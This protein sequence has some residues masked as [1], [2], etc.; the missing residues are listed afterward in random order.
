MKESFRSQFDTPC[1]VIDEEI[2]RANIR[3][4]QMEAQRYGCELRP[5][6]KTHKTAY[7]AKLQLEAGAC[8]ITSCKVSEAERMAGA[9]MDD[10][11]I[12]Y[13][14]VGAKKLARACALSK[15]IKRL[16][17]AVDNLEQARPL[18]AAAEANHCELEVRIEVDC[19]GGRTGSEWEEFA[20][21]VRFVEGAPGLRLTGLYTFRGL[22]GGIQEPAGAAAREVELMMAYA[23]AAE[24]ICGRKLE[25]S[26]GST[27]T[28]RE[29]A[30]TGKVTEIRPGTYVFSDYM[31]HKECAAPLERIAARL[32]VTVVSVHKDYVVV[33]GGCKTFPTDPLL[34]QPPYFFNSYAYFPDH[35][36]LR[37]RKLTE[38]HGMVTAEGGPLNLKVGDILEAIPVHICPA[39]NLQNQIYIVNGEQIREE[40][41]IGR[42]MLQ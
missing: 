36:H 14:L 18:A 17:L 28:G 12:A 11:F 7:F 26:G 15:Q 32:L 34:D 33:D 1:L 30:Q 37:L 39:V 40:L 10:I 38:E 31:M 41:V 25:I 5:H 4:M 8:G 27:P 23:Q 20:P 6:I 29:V 16:I 3:D 9:G 19:G 42:G 21:L 2:A 22:N 35:P 13:P 24:E